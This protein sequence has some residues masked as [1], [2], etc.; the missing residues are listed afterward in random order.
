MSPCKTLEAVVLKNTTLWDMA[1][2]SLVQSNENF[3][4]ANCSHTKV[5]ILRVQQNLPHIYW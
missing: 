5:R 4:E 1:L 3:E 2:C